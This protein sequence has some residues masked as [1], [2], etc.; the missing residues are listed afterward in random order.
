MV[1][2]FFSS[3]VHPA[4]LIFQF[5]FAVIFLLSQVIFVID[6]I[7]DV[8]DYLSLLFDNLLSFNFTSLSVGLSCIILITTHFAFIF[9]Q[10][11]LFSF[12]VSV[13][14]LV[15]LFSSPSS[16][17]KSS[18]LFFSC[19]IR[20]VLFL[21]FFLMFFVPLISDLFIQIWTQ[22]IINLFIHEDSLDQSLE[23]IDKMNT[24]LGLRLGICI[25][26]NLQALEES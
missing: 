8:E 9:F 17:D 5:I 3:I 26:F 13:S 25:N 22:F 6:V 2:N 20:S 4:K 11:W 1:Q 23:N 18:L 19:H 24:S 7:D 21:L 10:A 14:L 15:E 12:L 16:N